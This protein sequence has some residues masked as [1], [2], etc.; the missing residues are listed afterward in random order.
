L[1]EESL[2]AQSALTTG[3]Q[4]R[5]GTSGVLIEATRITGGTSFRQRQTARIYNTRD[6]RMAKDKPKNLTK[7]NKDHSA[8][9]K[10]G[11]PTTASP[12]Y[13][14]TPNKQGSE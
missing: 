12:G 7:R 5:V 2:S 4:E 13:T 1:A 9:S 10:R 6:Y 11:T 14:N 8:S 3:I